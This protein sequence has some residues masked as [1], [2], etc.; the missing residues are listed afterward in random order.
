MCIVGVRLGLE[1]LPQRESGGHATW[2]CVSEKEG[3][4][5]EC[6]N[7]LI[8]RRLYGGEEGGGEE[9]ARGNLRDCYWLRFRHKTIPSQSS[10]GGRLGV[11]PKLEDPQGVGGGGFVTPRM[12]VWKQ[13]V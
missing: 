6:G 9:R 13:K 5:G 11:R 3:S 1:E 7:A 8:R 12:C 10:R 4:W 2:V